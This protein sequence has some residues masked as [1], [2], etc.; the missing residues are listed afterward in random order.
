M[1]WS[2]I[3]VQKRSDINFNILKFHKLW[4]LLFYALLLISGRKMSSLRSSSCVCT[5]YLSPTRT[6]LM[7][8]PLCQA[9]KWSTETS[10]S[11][12]QQTCVGGTTSSDA[13]SRSQSSFVSRKFLPKVTQNEAFNG[14][15]YNFRFWTK[16]SSD[17]TKDPLEITA[18]SPSTVSRLVSALHIDLPWIVF[19]SNSPKEG[20]KQGDTQNSNNNTTRPLTKQGEKKIHAIHLRPESTSAYNIE[21]ATEDEHR[22]NEKQSKAVIATENNQLDATPPREQHNLEQAMT[23]I[24][25]SIAEYHKLP[26]N[27]QILQ[28]SSVPSASY[29]KDSENASSPNAK[30]FAKHPSQIR[31]ESQETLLQQISNLLPSSITGK[32]PADKPTVA[33]AKN[34]ML[35][36][37][38]IDSKTRGLVQNLRMAKSNQS[39]LKR[40]EELCSHLCD[41]PEAKTLAV[42]V[43]LS[44]LISWC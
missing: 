19:Q 22:A 12:L 13:H 16:L 30:P 18:A 28:S 36:K 17:A 20:Q 25:N 42:R 1:L 43:S 10:P 27:G 21:S 11:P 31:K 35:A 4:K 33:K 6:S 24:H 40:L 41:Y 32:Q 38:S 29:F 34:L 3:N 9:S 44:T 37:R 39:R 7:R 15:R 26:N 2:N 23:L 5:R 14:S 8:R